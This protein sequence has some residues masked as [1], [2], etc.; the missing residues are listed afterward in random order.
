VELSPSATGQIGY[1]E[2]GAG[3]DVA[4]V[5]C[6]IDG[7]L[8][9]EIMRQNPPRAGLSRAFRSQPTETTLGE[10][11]DAGGLNSPVDAF[12]DAVGR[13]IPRSGWRNE[14]ISPAEVRPMNSDGV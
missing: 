7:L 10:F 9:R 13:R 12:F 5:T 1:V 4:G 6:M 8:E 2:T 3:V 11:A 14:V